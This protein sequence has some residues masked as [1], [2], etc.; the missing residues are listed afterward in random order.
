MTGG[1]KEPFGSSFEGPL[2]FERQIG[3]TELDRPRDRSVSRVVLNPLPFSTP[4]DKLALLVE[5]KVVKDRHSV[6]S[7][8][9]SRISFRGEM[10][11]KP[12]KAS[13]NELLK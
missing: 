10:I 9:P 11:P 2:I 7:D 13:P 8:S 6:S 1:N 5:W 12:F 4:E 3:A